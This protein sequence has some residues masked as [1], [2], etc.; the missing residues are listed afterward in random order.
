VE[1]AGGNFSVAYELGSMSLP[2]RIDSEKLRYSRD[3]F[4]CG[5][6]LPV[7]CV[8]TLRIRLRQNCGSAWLRVRQLNGMILSCRPQRIRV[9][10]ETFSKLRD[11][12]VSVGR[13]ALPR[14]LQQCSAAFPDRQ[15]A[16]HRRQSF[17]ADF[18]FCQVSKV[19]A[20][21]CGRSSRQQESCLTRKVPH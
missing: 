2:V 10:V 14:R 11:K 17:F 8:R 9:G 13:N 21:I 1:S 6:V 3:R 5:F 7:E 4:V 12:F 19:S 15:E 18:A 20:Q 16:Q